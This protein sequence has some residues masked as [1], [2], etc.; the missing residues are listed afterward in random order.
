M[1]K[2]IYDRQM[3]VENQFVGPVFGQLPLQWKNV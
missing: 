2:Y 3:L 1:F